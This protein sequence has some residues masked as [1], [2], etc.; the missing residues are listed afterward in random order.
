MNFDQHDIPVELVGGP[1]CGLVLWFPFEGDEICAHD[2]WGRPALLAAGPVRASIDG[3]LLYLL[4]PDGE[5]RYERDPDTEMLW[6][7]VPFCRL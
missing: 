3:D 2:S 6:R 1:L 7:F 4:L 5:V